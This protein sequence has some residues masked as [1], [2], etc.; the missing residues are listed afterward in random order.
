MFQQEGN[1]WMG[2]NVITSF[3]DVAQGA[4]MGGRG[5]ADREWEVCG[6]GCGFLV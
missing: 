1:L 5:G 3:R 6:F 4:C 2:I